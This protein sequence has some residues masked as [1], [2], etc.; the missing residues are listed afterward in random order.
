VGA[1]LEVEEEEEELDGVDEDVVG[2]EEP[3]NPNCAWL[4]AA[5]VSALARCASELRLRFETRALA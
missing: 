3:S 5:G 2:G 4:C 1:T